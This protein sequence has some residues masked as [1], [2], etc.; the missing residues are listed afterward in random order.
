M[1][2]SPDLKLA[3]RSLRTVLRAASGMLQPLP[4]PAVLESRPD[5]LQHIAAFGAN[6]GG[7]SMLAYVPPTLPA[8]SPIVVLLHGCGQD[9]A[10][11]AEDGGWVSLADRLGLALLLP[12]QSDTNNRYRCFNWFR[13]VHAARGR[14]EAQSIRSMTATAVRRLRADPRRIYVAGLSAGAAMTTVM[15]ASY[16]DVFAAGAAVAGL[17]VGAANG[18]AA[19]LARMARAGPEGRT[20]EDWADLARHVGPRGYSGDWPRLSIWHGQLDPVVDPA[21]SDLIA[22]QW[23]ALHG[24]EHAPATASEHLGLRHFAWG[25]GRHPAVELW[26]LPT[27]RHGYPTDMEGDP[28]AYILPAGISATNEIARFWGLTKG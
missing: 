25:D 9:I 19:A 13:P 26:M 22:Q 14:G 2:W 8:T 21:N 6:P 23:R 7:L 15:L 27:L 5:D 16:P 24:L 4:A 12:E 18:G 10:R 1:L 3:G 11:F 20:T 17:P 28:A